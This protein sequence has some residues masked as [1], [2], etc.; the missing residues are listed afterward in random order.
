MSNY[1]ILSNGGRFPG[2]TPTSDEIDLAFLDMAEMLDQHIPQYQIFPFPTGYAW[3]LRN[4]DP[5]KPYDIF[6]IQLLK[7]GEVP[8]ISLARAL[9]LAE[10]AALADTQK[11]LAV[12]GI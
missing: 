12:N 5:K 9:E 8:Q 2:S 6:S 10:E 1:R 11:M 4:T 3:E 7:V